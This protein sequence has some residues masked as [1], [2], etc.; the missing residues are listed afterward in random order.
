MSSI[1]TFHRSPGWAEV[2]SRQLNEMLNRVADWDGRGGVPPTIETAMDAFDVVCRIQSGAF[3]LPWFALDPDGLIEVNWI[4]N[5]TRIEIEVDGSGE[6]EVFQR[7][8]GFADVER[9]VSVAK[10]DFR[11]VAAALA[12]LSLSSDGQELV[13]SIS[14]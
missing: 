5:G 10:G 3:P 11:F 12:R 13:G 2:V 4:K 14:Q 6:A 7:S 8:P 9:R 1:E